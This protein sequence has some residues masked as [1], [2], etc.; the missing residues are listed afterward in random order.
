M[1][2]HPSAHSSLKPKPKYLYSHVGLL[3]SSAPANP[4]MQ[5]YTQ[6]IK[7]P[8]HY[9]TLHTAVQRANSL[10]NPT[11]SRSM[12]Q[13]PMQP[14]THQINMPTPYTTLHTEDQHAN[15]LCHPTHSRSKCQCPMQSY[16]QQINM[17]TPY[18]TLYTADQRVQFRNTAMKTS[19]TGVG[20]AWSLA[21]AHYPPPQP[22]SSLLKF[23]FS[24]HW[25]HSMDH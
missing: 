25:S 4:P 15:S 10:C 7:V 12:C 1:S 16:T 20:G 17:P 19:M 21:P 11:Q 2:G 9:A 5:P 8:T 24:S 14:Y 18:A 6:Q 22:L 13:P 23:L 3:H